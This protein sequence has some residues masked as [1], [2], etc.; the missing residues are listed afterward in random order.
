MISNQAYRVAFEFHRKWSPC[1]ATAADWEKA[2][3]DMCRISGANN[4]DALLIDLLVA[5][6]NDLEREWKE[7]EKRGEVK[8][9]FAEYIEKGG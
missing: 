7:A 4:N 6:F 5:V 9:D 8:N 3:D 1:P 2:T